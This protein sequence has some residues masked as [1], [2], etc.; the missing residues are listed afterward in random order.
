MEAELAAVRSVT[1][2][3][4]ARLQMLAPASGLPDSPFSM[5]DAGEEG[6]LSMD[7]GREGADA[8]VG[9]RPDN[10]VSME[11]PVVDALA[12]KSFDS[13]VQST[14]TFLLPPA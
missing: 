10:E 6:S 8:S 12:R 7:T 9:A 4:A 13:L 1:D 14:A 11:D 3:H 5:V 2:L